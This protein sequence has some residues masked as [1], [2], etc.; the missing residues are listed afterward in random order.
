MKHA[1]IVTVL[2]FG[3]AAHLHAQH[4]L[5]GG[6]GLGATFLNVDELNSFRDTYNRVNFSNLANLMGSLNGVEG[7]RFEV[8]YRY[9]SHEPKAVT[10]GWQRYTRRTNAR[11]ANG[12]NRV[13]DLSMKSFYLDGEIG[14]AWERFFLNALAGLTFQRDIDLEALYQGLEDTEDTKRLDGIYQSDT[15][16][17]G[18]IGIVGGYYHRIAF[19][20]AKITYPVFAT[21]SSARLRDDDPEKIADGTALFPNDYINFIDRVPYDGVPNEVDGL[22]ISISVLFALEL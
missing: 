1:T 21:D 6:L 11:F 15:A 9:H 22:Q 14:K 17:T 16:L 4:Y 7:V 19:L 5:T 13:L 12:E 8:G 2:V 3:L 20:I 10:L 18:R